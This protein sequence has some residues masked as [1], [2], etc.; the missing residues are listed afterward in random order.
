M[1]E[2]A[3]IPRQVVVGVGLADLDRILQD[4]S[5]EQEIVEDLPWGVGHPSPAVLIRAIAPQ[6]A[7]RALLLAEGFPPGIAIDDFAAVRFEG[8][9]LAEVVTAKEGSAA[10]RVGA[11]GESVLA[12]RFVG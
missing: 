2:V 3:R 6:V 12:A 5:I 10:Y 9:E 7:A 4:P 11:S 1:L 8:T